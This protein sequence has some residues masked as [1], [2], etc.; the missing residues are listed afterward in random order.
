M[1][2]E[3]LFFFPIPPGES[4]KKRERESRERERERERE[5]VERERERERAVQCRTVEQ[6]L[7]WKRIWFGPSDAK[8]NCFSSAVRVPCTG[9][10]AR[11]PP[12]NVSH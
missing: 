12:Q 7:A 1:T 11:I 2:V 6:D 3:K 4:E 10:C 8:S 9:C 5:R